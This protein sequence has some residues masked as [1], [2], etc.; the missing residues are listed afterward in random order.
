MAKQKPKSKHFIVSYEVYPFDLMVSFN[1]PKDIFIKRLKNRMPEDMHH[2]VDEE[3]LCKYTARTVMFSG[4][5][6]AIHFTFWP[7]RASQYALIAHEI[8]HAVC[9]LMGNLNMKLSHENDEAYAYL[10]Q[11][12]TEQIYKKLW[13]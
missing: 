7:E 6:T 3:F 5:M 10:L 1:E 9:F 13:T 4:G 8:F 2:E 11:Y 12:I